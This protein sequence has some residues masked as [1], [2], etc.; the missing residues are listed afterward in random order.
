[1]PHDL[2]DL[3]V[4]EVIATQIGGETVRVGEALRVRPVRAEQD[5]LEPDQVLE[6]TKLVLI[7]RRRPDVLAQLLD[8]VRRERRRALAIGPS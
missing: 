5:V 4:I 7:E 2:L 6:L 1:M 3:G 8:R